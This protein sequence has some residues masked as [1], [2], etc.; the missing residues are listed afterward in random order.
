M[1]LKTERE[2]KLIITFRKAQQ[3]PEEVLIAA[4]NDSAQWYRTKV[5]GLYYSCSWLCFRVILRFSSQ[6][7]FVWV[8]H[9]FLILRT[10]RVI[11]IQGLCRDKYYAQYTVL[12]MSLWKGSN[13]MVVPLVLTSISNSCS[14]NSSVGAIIFEHLPTRCQI[15][16]TL[17]VLAWQSVLTSEFPCIITHSLHTYAESAFSRSQ[18]HK[19]LMKSNWRN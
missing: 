2:H 11:Q 15:A 10:L 17:R 13:A 5:Q 18:T 3:L 14:V 16:I 7:C 6:I 4:T 12:C 8:L 19:R 1:R 9:F